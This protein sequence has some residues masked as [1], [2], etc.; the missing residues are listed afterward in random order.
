MP[1]GAFDFLEVIDQIEPMR[2]CGL[3][4]HEIFETITD[5]DGDA[6]IA[7]NSLPE[8]GNEIADECQGIYDSL[9]QELVPTFAINGTL[10]EVELAYSNRYHA[11]ANA[12]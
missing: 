4:S 8:E 6:W 1:A 12:P 3:F 9:S 7:N 5:P 11:C 10:Y 2:T